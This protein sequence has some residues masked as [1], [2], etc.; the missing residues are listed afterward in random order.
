LGVAP[1]GVIEHELSGRESLQ[2]VFDIHRCYPPRDLPR[3]RIR[4][5]S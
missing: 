2:Q 1:D 4:G 3:Q 5:D